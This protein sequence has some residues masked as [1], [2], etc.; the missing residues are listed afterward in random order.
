MIYLDHP[1]VSSSSW[2]QRRCSSNNLSWWRYPLSCFL[3][4]LL[5]AEPGSTITPFLISFPIV[6]TYQNVKSITFTVLSEEWS[7][8]KMVFNDAQLG[9]KRGKKKE[10]Q[11][12]K[13]REGERKRNRRRKG[14]DQEER[15]RKTAS[16]LDIAR[17][18]MEHWRTSPWSTTVATPNLF[19]FSRRL[20]L[21]HWCFYFMYISIV[22]HLYNNFKK[23]MYILFDY[24]WIKN[25]EIW[26]KE[27]LCNIWCTR[28][29]YL[30]F[31]FQGLY[32]YCVQ[33]KS[34]QS[35]YTIASRFIMKSHNAYIGTR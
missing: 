8:S 17:G 28:Y 14:D 3:F 34:Y 26:Q 35:S 19:S 9:W 1:N 13:K 22:I 27:M 5:L 15:E 12:E 16:M 10:K 20:S 33:R 32:S 30:Q 25:R 6:P 29:L 24:Y 18:S 2:C 7:K 23:Y 21:S 4:L 11:R 31:I